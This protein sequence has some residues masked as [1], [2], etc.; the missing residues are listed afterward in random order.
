[1]LEMAKVTKDDI[2]YDLGCGDGRF[3]I[4]AAKI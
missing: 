2:V 1:M 3:V 4:T